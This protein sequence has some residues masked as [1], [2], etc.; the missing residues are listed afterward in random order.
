MG[1][2]A[3]APVGPAG[4][5]ADRYSASSLP[6]GDVVPDPAPP[7]P[8]PGPDAPFPAQS[9]KLEAIPPRGPPDGVVKP[10]GG[11]GGEDSG[12]DGVGLQH[13]DRPSSPVSEGGGQGAGTTRGGSADGASSPQGAA[14]MT[15]A[16]AG[17]RASTGSLYMKDASDP[18][19]LITSFSDGRVIKSGSTSHTPSHSPFHAA[20]G[21]SASAVSTLAGGAPAP[22]PSPL[23]LPVGAG[24]EEARD[25]RNTLGGALS[26]ARVALSPLHGGDA[27]DVSDVT[28]VPAGSSGGD[29][30][31]ASAPL[32]QASHQHHQVANSLRGTGAVGA[33]AGGSDS[34]RSAT[35]SERAVMSVGSSGSLFP[36]GS[37]RPL[38]KLPEESGGGSS[39]ESSAA[40][41]KAG[42]H[43]SRSR[44]AGGGSTSTAAGGGGTTGGSALSD[45]ASSSAALTVV[46]A[47]ASA[48]G[49]G[50]AS[51]L[52]NGAGRGGDGEQLGPSATT[53]PLT[54]TATVFVN[55]A[56]IPNAAWHGDGTTNSTRSATSAT[57]HSPWH[58]GEG[59]LLPPA[60]MRP[61]VET[62]ALSRGRLVPKA[63]ASARSDSGPVQALEPAPLG[64]PFPATKRLNQYYL[65][66]VLGRGAYSKVRLAWNRDTRESVAI[67]VMKKSYLRRRRI[68]RASNAFNVV[69]NEV[70]VWR[71]VRHPNIVA[72]LEVRALPIRR[73]P[74]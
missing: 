62:A 3:S 16:P 24:G 43:S 60:Y 45:G 9:G 37:M 52:H 5:P 61:V 21:G 71:T 55:A 40:S 54:V 1:C 57:I 8:R 56:R 32:S 19:R 29:D 69:L 31:T 74:S 35:L 26:S 41:R 44:E 72:L 18:G 17:T 12:V 15:F 64:L 65:G 10:V 63:A 73:A 13:A 47:Q 66:R 14:A 30:S 50:A 34:G 6:H 51:L 67:K 53:S 28:A 2:T 25:G 11:A 27:A 20:G 38:A 70:N 36:V 22:L 39:D 42:S 58:G 4:R 48:R 33:G 49:V 23:S 7:D 68:G 46:T 59:A